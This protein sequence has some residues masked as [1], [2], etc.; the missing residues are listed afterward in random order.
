RWVSPHRHGWLAAVFLSVFHGLYFWKGTEPHL[1]RHLF[2][3]VLILAKEVAYVLTALTQAGLAITEPGAA[4][5]DDACVDGHVENAA[6]EGDAL[7]VEDVELRG[8]ERRCHLVLHDL[9]LD[10][11]AH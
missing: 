4:L 11:I 1:C 6:G 5:V 8:S 9:H 7:V 10:A 3:E 2:K